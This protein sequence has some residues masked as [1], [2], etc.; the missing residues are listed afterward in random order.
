MSR[1]RARVLLWMLTTMLA[2]RAPL[3]AQPATP[4]RAA[5]GTVTGKVIDKSTGDPIIEAGVEVVDVGK[6]ARTDLDGKYKLQLPAGTYQL[7]IFAP[8]YRGTRLQNVV[9]RAAQVT[10]SDAT[11][12]PEGAAAVEVVEVVAQAD[13]ATEAAQLLQRQK[14]AVVE[15]NISAQS[16]QKS[17]DKNAADVVKRVPAVTIQNG[18]F[19]FVRGLGERYTSAVLNSSRLPSTDPDRRVVPLDLFPAEF[20]ESL[21]VI[22]TYTPDLPG[23][24]SGGLVDIKLREYPEQLSYGIGMQTTVNTNA[25][26]Q[27]FDTYHGSQYDYF[28]FGADFRDQPRLVP[29]NLSGHK[30]SGAQ[31]RFYNS[32]FKNVWDVDKQTS[33][34]NYRL[35]FAVGDSVD[36]GGFSLAGIYGTEYKE[37]WNEFNQVFHNNGKN[38]DGRRRVVSW[39]SLP[40]TTTWKRMPGA[41]EPWGPSTWIFSAHLTIP[42]SGGRRLRSSWPRR[43][44]GSI[45]PM[46]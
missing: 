46:R 22:K 6:R 36:S 37:R 2:S 28:G 26:F 15:D 35:N 19:V 18:K 25:S 41:H 14:S 23:D 43:R 24:F 27:P 30:V 8:L 10:Q 9:V 12:A 38:P 7:R 16:I 34:P 1:G 13:K 42:S 29:D 32:Q 44:T 33:A 11:L 45:G 3:V 20:M 17:P 40:T 39:P 5:D 31:G 21:S 4:E